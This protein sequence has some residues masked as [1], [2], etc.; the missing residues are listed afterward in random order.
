MVRCCF[1][2]GCSVSLVVTPGCFFPTSWRSRMLGACVVRLWSH[3]V[4]PVFHKLL[5]LG[6]CV[7]RLLPHVFDSAGSAGVIFGLTRVVVKAFTLFRYFVVLC[8]RVVL[9]LLIRVPA[10][11]A[12]R[13][14]LS[15]EFVAGW[16]W[17]RFVAPCVASS[18]FE[19]IAYLTGLNSNPSGSSNLWVAAR[20]SRVPGGGPGGRVVTVMSCRRCQLDYPCCSL[21]ECCRPRCG[22][23]TVCLAIVL[24]RLSFCS[25]A[26]P[27]P[28]WWDFVCPHGQEVCFISR[29][30]WALPDG[31]LVSAMGVWLVVLLWKC[32]SRLVVSPCVWKRLVV[33]VLLPYFPLVA[34]GG[35]AFT[36]HLVPC[37]APWRP[38]WR[39][40]LPLCCLEVELVA[41]LVCM[42]L[43]SVCFACASAVLGGTCRC[44]VCGPLRLRG[45]SGALCCGLLRANIVVV[46]LK[47]LDFYWHPLLVLEWFVF[48]PSRALVHCVALWVAPGACVSTVGCAIFPDR[49]LR[50]SFREFARCRRCGAFRLWNTLCWSCLMVVPL[51]LWGGCF[52]LSRYPYR[53]YARLWSWLVSGFFSLAWE[54]VCAVMAPYFGLGPFEVDV[55][56]L[57]SAVVLFSVRLP[58]S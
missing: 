4:A 24:A 54:R 3:V 9:L 14:S 40:S 16:S 11:L 8:S 43:L 31:S 23:F 55:L 57:T 6:R 36:W 38:L 17:W 39:R 47:L 53:W 48:L 25:F 12:G 32:Q 35:S 27:R 26:C 30:L 41:P 44:L 42:A 49:E 34:Q 50:A 18:L 46:L 29:A 51:P 2:H 15:Q 28:C 33:R 7:L 1:S 52:A 13:D 56:P 19:F 20:P 5:C 45:G 37:R 21:P 10:A 22:A 58:T